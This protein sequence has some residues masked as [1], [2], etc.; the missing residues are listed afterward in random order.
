MGDGGS[1]STPERRRP[2]TI[3]EVARRA[4]VSHQTVSRYLRDNGGVRPKTRENIDEAIAALNYT[5]NL[6]ARS[7]RTR[8]SNRIIL[9]LPDTT[10]FVPSDMVH[11]AAEAAHG[12]G[13]VLDV[14][15]V[16]GGSDQRAE[17]AVA[18]L[19]DQHLAGILSLAPLADLESRSDGVTEHAPV[20]VMGE[21]DDQMRSQGTLAD[22]TAAGTIVDYLADLGHRRFF[23]L[24]GP[25]PWPAARNRYAAYEEAIARRG[26]ESAGFAIGDWSSQSGYDLAGG[27]ADQGVT[28]VVAA[29]D[30]MALG[31]MRRLYEGGVRVPADVSVFGWDDIEESRFVIPALSTVR[32]NRREQGRDAASDL[33]A[34]IRGEVVLRRS[35]QTTM[36]L[37]LRESTG[38]VRC[39]E[40]ARG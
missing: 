36:E 35:R 4:G 37:I 6:A 14:V 28:A 12:A 31:V 2:A 32:M 19:K 21:Y 23:H 40:P 33:I 22:G 18:L 17:Q 34:M 26:L 11:G 29:N 7:M 10:Q 20:L 15:S 1:G 24:A 38:P 25:T 13:Y 39:E 3:F 8:K 5:P 30:R 9:L 27:L 16:E